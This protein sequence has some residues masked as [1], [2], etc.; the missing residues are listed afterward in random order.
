MNIKSI[1]RGIALAA[2]VAWGSWGTV[3]ARAQGVQFHVDLG[4][5]PGASIRFGSAPPPPRRFEPVR[6]VVPPAA[7]RHEHY[8]A[9]GYRGGYRNPYREDYFRRFRPGYHPIVV[10]GAQYYLYPEL[11][12]GCQTV[13]VN[14]VTYYLCDGVYYQPYFYEGQTQFMVVPPPVP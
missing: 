7:V 1:P 14:G 5:H 13:V 3:E 10:S 2:V 8:E 4:H 9:P 12:P 11:P 6:P